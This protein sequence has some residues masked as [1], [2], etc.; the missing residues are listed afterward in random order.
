MTMELMELGK[1][2]YY[3]YN[4]SNACIP[5]FEYKLEVGQSAVLNLWK[6]VIT[7]RDIKNLETIP[8]ENVL[9]H[10]RKVDKLEQII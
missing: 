9:E 2:Y 8:V 10:S 7:K 4:V 1:Y 3:I 5:I 6:I